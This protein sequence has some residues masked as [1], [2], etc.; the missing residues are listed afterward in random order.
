ME[1]VKT[2]PNKKEWEVG[3]PYSK[4]SGKKPNQKYGFITAN[5]E[6]IMK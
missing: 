1:R 5:F 4:I 3:N 2:A 6:V